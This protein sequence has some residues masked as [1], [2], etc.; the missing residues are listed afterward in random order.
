[1]ATSFGIMPTGRP[2]WQSRRAGERARAACR[3]EELGGVAGGQ[4]W[5]QWR[6][7]PDTL[8]GLL[9]E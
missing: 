9:S 3:Q 7:N 8:S 1:M 2:N 4:S 5:P 6:K